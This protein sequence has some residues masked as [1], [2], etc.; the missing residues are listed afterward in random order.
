MIPD[1]D[2][3][4]SWSRVRIRWSR[5]ES[6]SSALSRPVSE[7][8]SSASQR[9]R[10]THS[11]PRAPGRAHPGASRE[12]PSRVYSEAARFLETASVPAGERGERGGQRG[13]TT[14]G[15]GTNDRR[16]KR[17][18]RR[19]T[20]PTSR[21]RRRTQA[22][23]ERSGKA[24]P[25]GTVA[26][27]YAP[28]RNPF[29]KRR[30][31]VLRYLMRPV[32]VVRRPMAFVDQLSVSAAEGGRVSRRDFCISRRAAGRRCI[33]GFWAGGRRWDRDTY[34]S[35]CGPRGSRTRRT[36][37]S[38]CGRSDDHTCDVEREAGAVASVHRV[39]NPKVAFFSRAHR[40]S[41]LT[42]TATAGGVWRRT[43]CTACGS[44][45]SSCRSS[46]YLCRSYPW[47]VCGA[48]RKERRLRRAPAFGGWRQTS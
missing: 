39:E 21:P 24:R 22:R 28:S 1:D 2:A 5:V 34:S 17:A 44:C 45:S 19:P 43:A 7:C 27:E 16:A 3:S 33:R 23:L 9:H 15:T 4:K 30:G 41:R 29:L 14:D 6:S 42:A 38:G 8:S 37:T 35:S 32:P 25:R 20:R 47:F 13:R 48:T 40:I 46:R 10:A 31:R 36:W 11:P 18:T 26:R 12:S